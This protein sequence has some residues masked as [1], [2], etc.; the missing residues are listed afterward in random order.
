LLSR[1]IAVR[2]ERSGLTLSD[3][4]R[5]LLRE[6]TDRF[7]E[8]AQRRA[9]PSRSA[10]VAMEAIF[11]LEKAIVELGDSYALQSIAYRKRGEPRIGTLLAASV[12][13]PAPL[14]SP[15]TEAFFNAFNSV[16]I[17]LNWADIETD[18]G[19]YDYEQAEKSIQFCSNKGMR[20]IGGPLID[21]RDRLMPHWL[22]LM[23][24]DFDA[25]LGSVTQFVERTVE[26]FRGSVHLWNCAAGLNTPGPMD[27]DDEKAMRLAVGILQTVRKT[28]PN[29]PTIVSFDQPFG[30]YLAKHRD[31]ISPL[32][33]ADALVRSGL[34]MAG[35]G[36]EFRFN[37]RNDATLPRSAVD[38]GQ[39]ID[40]WATLGMPLLVQLSV[41]GQSGVDPKSIAPQDVLECTISS[42]DLA[43]EQ[44]RIA[45][46]MI[47]TLLAKHIVHGVVWDGWSD[48]DPH[49]M[50][51]S[52]LIDS[53]GNARPLLEYLT[54]VRREFLA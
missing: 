19:R 49:V 14:G 40:R 1:T 44:L 12:I 6:G 36:L 23:E 31:G 34:G 27:L 8:A 37:Y 54:R 53:N 45:G 13:P 9:D 41:P 20:I 7:L 25:F 5:E 3:E 30:E 28:D 22:Y 38:F 15:D 24:D 18:S 16:S 29:T 47:R 4:F 21:F 26:N 32:H 33:F 52:G 48:A 43:S 17:R 11:L 46:P 39:M 10:V 50:S 51:H 35:I 2:W 42:P